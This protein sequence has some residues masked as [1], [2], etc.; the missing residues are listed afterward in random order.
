MAFDGV[1][2]NYFL[3]RK[4]ALMAQNADADTS[5]ASS[6]AISAVAGAEA[7]RAAANVDNVRAGLMP[8]ESQSQIGLQTAQGRVFNAQAD[9][10]PQEGAARIGQIKADTA[11]T[12]TQNKVLTRNS[13]TGIFGGAP[14]SLPTLQGAGALA[15]YN[16]SSDPEVAPNTRPSASSIVGPAVLPTARKPGESYAAWTARLKQMG[17]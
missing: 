2:F 10:I 14:G 4:Y 6:A 11:F 16:F 5:R 13:L 8:A 1:D 12:G 9:L 3:N 7:A 15:G 17:Y